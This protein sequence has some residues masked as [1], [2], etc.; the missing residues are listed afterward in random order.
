M[1]NDYCVQTRRQQ[2]ADG[3]DVDVYEPCDDFHWTA[4]AKWIFSSL[5]DRDA[6]TFKKEANEALVRAVA[7]RIPHQ[8]ALACE[9][10]WI[11]QSASGSFLFD[12][13]G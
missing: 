12:C 6:G 2:T 9:T 13:F 5:V 3:R 1:F 7:G 4:E 8:L 10:H 11:S